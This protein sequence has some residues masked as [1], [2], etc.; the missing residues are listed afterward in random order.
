MSMLWYFCMYHTSYGASVVLSVYV[1]IGTN[2]STLV[3]AKASCEKKDR[4][5][6]HGLRF[7]VCAQ[8]GFWPG[9]TS[10]QGELMQAEETAWVA[11]ESVLSA[12]CRASATFPMKSA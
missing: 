12:A 5:Q 7:Q 3:L 9:A 6:G 2:E 8:S 4:I 11:T 1:S 10:R